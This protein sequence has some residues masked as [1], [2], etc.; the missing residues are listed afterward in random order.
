M[1]HMLDSFK[2][3]VA[4]FRKDQHGM[5]T[6]EFAMVLPLFMFIFVTAFEFGM[7]QTRQ[8]ML[9]HGLDRTVRLVRVGQIDE[10]KHGELITSVCSFATIIPDCA[11]QL[12]LQMLIVDVDDIGTQVAAEFDCRNR[13]EPETDPLLEFTNTGE[14]NQLM[15][16]RACALLDPFLPTWGIGNE[17]A[18]AGDNLVD[19]EG[20]YK[21]YASASYVLEPID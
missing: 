18:H 17:V 10:P 9:D 2:E 19:G 7:W 13:S 16:L 11:N 12:R 15:I 5:S 8:T 21:L 20:F 14:N 3:Q 1:I 4:R 6:I